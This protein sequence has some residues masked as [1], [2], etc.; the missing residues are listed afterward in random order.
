M[1]DRRYV[2]VLDGPQLSRKRLSFPAGIESI[3]CAD[4]V[5]LAYQT[6]RLQPLCAIIDAAADPNPILLAKEI[7]RACPGAVL[8]LVGGSYA[9]AESIDRWIPGDLDAAGQI[10]FLVRYLLGEPVRSSPRFTSRVRATVMS[11]DGASFSAEIC[12]LSESGVRLVAHEELPATAVMLHLCLG[13]AG[14]VTLRAEHV[15]TVTGV[16]AIPSAAAF[17]FTEDSEGRALLR[18]YLIGA[19][20]PERR[21]PIACTEPSLSARARSFLGHSAAIMD[22]VR[23]LERVAPTD[24]TVLLMGETG[25]GKALAAQLLHD[26]SRRRNERWVSV[27]CAALPENLVESELF[28]HEAGAFTGAMRRKLGLIEQAKN[29]TLFLDEVAELPMSGQAKLLHALEDRVIRRVGGCELIPVDFRLVAATNQNLRERVESRAFRRDLFFRLN[30]VCAVL[31]PLRDHLEDLPELLQHFV[32][33]A[34]QRMGKRQH[35]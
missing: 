35:P 27:N 7:K 3:W 24:V 15:R 23:L 31:P 9:D 8:A 34:Q 13:T 16:R 22:L 12:D 21:A 28:G 20:R 6:N 4:G 2:L 33:L 32:Q 14:E 25:T 1:P 29:G 19:R 5:A 10:T 18:R 26:A 30:V 11:A 17:R